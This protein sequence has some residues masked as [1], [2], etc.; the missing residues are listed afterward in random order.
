MRSVIIRIAYRVGPPALALL[1]SACGGSHGSGEGYGAIT[2]TLVW[3][4]SSAAQPSL[5]VPNPP[6]HW[7]VPAGV[8]TIY[9][10]V[11]ADDIDDPPET[12][13]AVSEGESG[14][15]IIE[16]VP[17]GTDRTLTVQGLDSS[18]NVR[19]QAVTEGI[20]V[21]AGGTEDIGE[22]VME[23][24]GTLSAGAAIAAGGLH[25]CALLDN[26]QVKCWGYNAFGQLG[27]GDASDRGD[28]SGEMGD[29]LP[30]VD[31]GT[32]RTAT[33]LAASNVHTC[34]LLDNNQ[35]RCWGS[36]VYGQL[37]LGDTSARGDNPGEMGD[38]LLAV[39]LGTG[40]TAT[41]LGAGFDHN[42]ALLDNGAV[43]CWGGNGNGQLGLGD[44][45]TRGDNAGE[46]GDNLPAV[47][48]GTG[49]SAAALATGG[50]YT[51]ALLDNGQVK[52]WGRNN[53]GQLGLGDTSYR[54]DGPGEMGD[55]LPAVDLG[56]GRTATALAAGT[57]HTCALLDN[58]QVKCWGE[59]GFGQLGLG[60]TSHR[61]DNSGEMGDNL[62]AVDLGTE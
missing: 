37:G 47:D 53:A 36:N 40:R 7:V 20:T 18:G 16:D 45:A 54:G 12:D 27:L 55:S 15:G 25:T 24:V 41:V 30:E 1:L 3:P 43:K 59:N 51:C 6:S 34:A 14:T 33:A 44:Q 62:P 46:M 29:N 9:A 28:Q 11:T 52:C 19:Y 32:G 38:S 48:L 17:V 10:V 4:P 57:N 2:A 22:V 8:V 13:I 21:T 58:G 42:C 35:V 49:R 60:D 50:Y 56:T 5:T 26:G 31:L 61:G 23:F 39:S